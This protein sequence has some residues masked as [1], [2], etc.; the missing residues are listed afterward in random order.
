ML[1]NNNL[2]KHLD[3][4]TIAEFSLNEIV[5]FEEIIQQKFLE[6]RRIEWEEDEANDLVHDREQKIKELFTDPSTRLRNFTCV[7]KSLHAT[8]YFLKV[9]D[10][11]LFY[12]FIPKERARQ[13]I[14]CRLELLRGQMAAIRQT[15]EHDYKELNKILAY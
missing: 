9:E 2:N 8:V 15:C 11:N 14:S 3:N 6:E 4:R 5:G 12:K 10:F 13:G 7:V 1:L